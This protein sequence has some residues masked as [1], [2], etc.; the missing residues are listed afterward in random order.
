MK[1]EFP[2]D[3]D[4]RLEQVDVDQVLKGNAASSESG[5]EGFAVAL[6]IL[7]VPRYLVRKGV[8]GKGV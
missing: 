4:S 3:D 2:E 7:R 8:H 1:I 6:N 5:C